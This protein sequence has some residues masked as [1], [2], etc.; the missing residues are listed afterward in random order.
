MNMSIQETTAICDTIDCNRGILLSISPGIQAREVVVTHFKA[1]LLG[2]RCIVGV[3][4]SSDTMSQVP[5]HLLRLRSSTDND[6]ETV[7]APRI[8]D[9]SDVF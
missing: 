5:A 9:D 4:L 6:V 8:S 1:T 2:V 3:L 7:L